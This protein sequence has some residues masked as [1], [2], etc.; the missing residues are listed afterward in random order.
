MIGKTILITQGI[1]AGCKAIVMDIADIPA[2]VYSEKYKGT[3]VL[4]VDILDKPM[5]TR[6]VFFDEYRE[7]ENDK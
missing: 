2:L 3:K 6:P 7:L 5:I 4:I 1:G